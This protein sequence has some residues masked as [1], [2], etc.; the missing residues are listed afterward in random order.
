MLF[1][2][3]LSQP[4]LSDLGVLFTAYVLF[5]VSGHVLSLGC[6]SVRPGLNLLLSVDAS[7]GASC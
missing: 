4:V 6:D 5:D 7:D 3:G 1:I 2:R